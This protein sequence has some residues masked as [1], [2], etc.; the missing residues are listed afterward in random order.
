MFLGSRLRDLRLNQKMSQDTL[1]SLLKVSK[2]AISNWENGKAVPS[3]ANLE[4]ISKVFGVDIHF[5][6][7]YGKL[8]TIFNGLNGRN[9]ERVI[10][11]ASQVAR[12]QANSSKEPLQTYPYLTYS[13]EAFLE[14][15]E[16]PSKKAYAVVTKGYI[17]RPHDF[18][19]WI[20]DD[21]L[22]P[23]F[24]IGE[25]ALLKYADKAENGQLYLVEFKGK[26]MFRQVYTESSYFKLIAYNTNYDTIFAP[27][28]EKP[29][30]IA[31][32]VGGFRPIEK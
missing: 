17:Q 14:Q 8:L 20:Q 5:F 4:K 11:F 24:Y 3:E 32:V 2:V 23:K 10:E 25:I 29:R 16:D 31:K 15:L 30:I 19:I 27:F 18:T 12:E 13:A 1:G 28:A 6:Y 7:S 9:Q 22:E 26:P 21:S